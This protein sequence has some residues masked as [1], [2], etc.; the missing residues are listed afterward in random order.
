MR[1]L[2][3]IV[4]LAC[5]LTAMGQPGR[6]GKDTLQLHEIQITEIAHPSRIAPGDSL[7]LVA[8]VGKKLEQISVNS[9][10]V[11]LLNNQAR[12]VFAHLPGMHVWESDASG[13]QVNVASRGL[14]PN[15]SWDFNVRQNGID[16]SADPVG[17]PE[18][19]YNP[20]MDVVSRI[21]VVRG[22]ASLQYGAQVGGLL[23]YQVGLP[24]NTQPFQAIVRLS[25]GAW[26]TRSSYA[27]LGIHRKKL[28]LQASYYRRSGDGWRAHSAYQTEHWYA[29]AE[30]ALHSRWKLSAALSRMSYLSAQTGGLT[31]TLFATQPDTT[32]RSRNWFQVPWWIPEL[33]LEGRIG[34]N[35]RLQL[36]IS[37]VLGER[38]S[39][40]ITSDMLQADTL[41]WS[42]GSFSPRRID[43]DYYAYAVAELRMLHTYTF[44]NQKHLLS[45]GV[46]VYRSQLDRKQ[47]GIGSKDSDFDLELQD[48]IGFRRSLRFQTSN[49]ALFAENT[50]RIGKRFEVVPGIRYERIVQ[51]GSGIFS[52][53][54]NQPNLWNPDATERA[55]VL[56]GLSTRYRF[57]EKWQV[58]GGIT[59]GYRP[60]L[61]AELT[62]P[63]TTDTI[64]AGLRDAR[65]L[66]SELGLR[67]STKNLQL[68]VSLFQLDYR[69]RV[70]TLIL[71]DA[72]GNKRQFRTN[73][74]TSQARGVDFYG[75]YQPYLSNRIPEFQLFVSGTLQEAIYTKLDVAAP[76]G[77]AE[78]NQSLKG[79]KVE[80][81]PEAIVRAGVQVRFRSLSLNWLSSYTGATFATATNTKEASANGNDGRIPEYLLHDLNVKWTWH[82][83]SELRAGISNL[84]NTSYFTRR[85]GGYPGPGILPG[86]PR[87]WWMSLEFRF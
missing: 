58:Y 78:P 14:S 9:Q 1:T 23:N 43:R 16:V 61:F 10:A 66:H 45:G 13:L 21:D 39:V 59:Q 42:T 71:T 82:P 11:P 67:W 75:A 31:D 62:P 19:Y 52:Y 73:T 3:C 63:A 8:L 6:M 81:A 70:G 7:G 55:F 34:A 22:S 50:F 4:P 35:T 74:G 60:V 17:Y 40:G 56:A 68:D 72:Q 53:T 47:N 80:N 84:A 5:G 44:K 32:L 27:A 46:R 49:L 69:D 24:E 77:S 12:Q 41:N 18:A 36:N 57:S 85:A 38:N 20:P 51:A 29:R 25:A 48:S 37:G 30:Y 28:N 76:S 2:L 65:S 33:K 83:Q 79:N 15:R 86:D 87:M 26:N 64:D 54:G